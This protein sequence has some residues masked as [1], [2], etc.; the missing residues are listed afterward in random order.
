[1]ICAVVGLHVSEDLEYNEEA[2]GLY[3]FLLRGIIS[4]SEM[5]YCSV[6]DEDGRQ[7]NCQANSGCYLGGRI[8]LTRLIARHQKCRLSS[9]SPLGRFRVLKGRVCSLRIF[10]RH[11]LA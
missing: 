4:I 10:V 3:R 5:C 1:M 11:V 8:L 9:M 2:S 7:T 6:E